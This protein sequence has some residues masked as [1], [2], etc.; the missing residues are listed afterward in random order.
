MT[1]ADTTSALDTD[2][3][4]D[5]PT[6]AVRRATAR[7][8]FT[9]GGALDD[10]RVLADCL[11]AEAVRARRVPTI[12]SLVDTHRATSIKV[13]T[14]AMRLLRERIKAQDA[15]SDA[16]TAAAEKAEKH[17]AQRASRARAHGDRV[18]RMALVS[19]E[20]ETATV[21]R[22]VALRVADVERAW[23][24][25]GFRAPDSWV[26]GSGESLDVV[27]TTHAHEPPRVDTEKRAVRGQSRTSSSYGRTYGYRRPKRHPGTSVRRLVFVRK[28]W[29]LDVLHRGLTS[30][31]DGG[32]P[33]FVLDAQPDGD[34]VRVSYVRAA[35][36]FSLSTHTARLRRLPDGSWVDADRPTR[37]RSTKGGV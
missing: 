33:T 32:R 19:W 12:A 34:A 29:R 21:A 25:A 5:T 26:Y 4:T 20:A 35:A 22:L 2:T 14:I 17:A 16:R 11:S 36:G 18:P 13:A 30:W 8:L 31:R 10:G 27:L 23:K 28:T 15:A 7:A 6:A 9:L 1:Y 37:R 24:A 3:D